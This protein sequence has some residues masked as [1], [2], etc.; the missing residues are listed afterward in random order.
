MG[1]SVF[2]DKCEI[3]RGGD[4][5]LL[6]D[7][8]WDA[9]HLCF[10]RGG[11]HVSWTQ[12]STY[13]RVKTM[14]VCTK[15][16]CINGSERVCLRRR[17]K[18]L[19]HGLSAGFRSD[20]S[21]IDGYHISHAARRVVTDRPIALSRIWICTTPAALCQEWMW[22][23]ACASANMCVRRNFVVVVILSVCCVT[24]Q[25]R[26]HFSESNT[27]GFSAKIENRKN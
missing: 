22:L 1:V 19:T 11:F 27:S 23:R 18:G 16:N 14:K 6:Q 10:D 13:Q 21:I 17:E 5:V 20:R 24:D 12:A 25:L 7:Y 8:A 3:P 2:Q 26:H 4:Q 9:N 15:R